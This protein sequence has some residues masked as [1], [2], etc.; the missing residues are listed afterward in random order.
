M[1]DSKLHGFFFEPPIDKY[2]LGYQFNEI[3]RENV[4]A[5]FLKDKR[6]LTIIDCGANIGATTY[7]FSRFAKIVHAIEP[8]IEHFNTLAYMVKFNNLTNVELYK[9]AIWI[10]NKKGKLYH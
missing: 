4:Y 3:Y 8:S 10:Q 5:P 2:F 7:Y 6:D 9:L 1:S